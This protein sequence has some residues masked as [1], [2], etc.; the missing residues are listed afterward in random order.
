M[1]IAF[2]SALPFEQPWFDQYQRHHQISYFPEPLTLTTVH[3]AKGHQAV[4]AFVNDE[5]SRPVLAAL[6]K[7]GIDVIGMRSLD[8][9]NVDKLAISKLGMT[10]LQVPGY[11]PYSVAEQ[12]ITLLLG[13]IRHLP[14]AH[15]RVQAGNFSIDGL[16]GTDLHGKTVGVIGTGHIGKAFIRIIQGFGCKAIAYDI[17]PDRKLLETGVQYVSLSELLQQSDIVSL[18]CPLTLLTEH[19]INDQTLSLFKPNAF[20]INTSRGQLVDTLS[21]LNALDNGRL[22]GYAADVYEYEQHY[23]HYD[24]SGKTIW[25][26]VLNRLRSHAKVLLTP[27]QGFFTKEAMTQ[28]ARGVLNQFSFYENQQTSPVTKASMC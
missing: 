10:L 9:D 20:L 7:Q 25:D 15:Q 1:K 5:L 26:E 12:A 23:F 13:L 22:A 24:F 19:L 27:H 8:V 4:C 18:H 2:F 14:K 17:Q 21:L 11:S 16:T 3:L 28:I 6:K